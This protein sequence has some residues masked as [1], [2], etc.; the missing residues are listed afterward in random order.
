MLTPHVLPP[1]ICIIIALVGEVGTQDAGANMD[2]ANMA[3]TTGKIPYTR[4]HT[5]CRA[6]RTVI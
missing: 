5:T 4:W 3:A 2:T 1:V 6:K